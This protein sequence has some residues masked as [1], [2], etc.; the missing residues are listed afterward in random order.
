M[1]SDLR[2]LTNLRMKKAEERAQAVLDAL[3]KEKENKRIEEEE[4][5]ATYREMT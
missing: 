4:Y 1:L 2:I 5:I 3:A